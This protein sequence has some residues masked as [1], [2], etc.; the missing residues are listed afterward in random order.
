MKTV[1]V[2]IDFSPFTQRVIAEAVRIARRIGARLVLLNVTQ[3]DAIRHDH[4]VFAHALGE[5][6]ERAGGSPAARRTYP[7]DGDRQPVSG[8]SIQLIGEPAQVILEQAKQLS[9][10][11]IVMGSHGH[12]ALFD[13]VLGSTSAKVLR[14][15]VCPVVIVPPGLRRVRRFLMPKLGT[16][17]T[18]SSAIVGCAR[19]G[20]TGAQRTPTPA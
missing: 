2:P 10:D 19:D 7:N 15:A 14:G 17:R 13:A 8:Y 9:A 12:S 4:E 5:P 16:N 11:Y 18:S 6:S 1:L 3:P 20:A